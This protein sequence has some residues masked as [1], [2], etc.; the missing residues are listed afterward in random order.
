MSGTTDQAVLQAIQ[1]SIRNC[2]RGQQVTELC[3]QAQCG[4]NLL[5][6]SGKHKF[7]QTE[8]HRTV[9]TG[10]PGSNGKD[11]QE[12]EDDGHDGNVG[13]GS[14]ATGSGSSGSLAVARDGAAVPNTIR[15][16]INAELPEECHTKNVQVSNEA[17]YVNYLRNGK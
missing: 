5:T 15:W 11:S 12:C 16:S 9:Y 2:T 7:A 17:D 4:Q 13:S 10:G 3:I 1:A 14:A 6:A 8:P